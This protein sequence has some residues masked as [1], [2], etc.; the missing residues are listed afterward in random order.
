MEHISKHYAQDKVSL[1]HWTTARL[2]RN[3]DLAV[4]AMGEAW[5]YI[6]ING[7][8]SRPRYERELEKSCALIDE[9]A[10]RLDL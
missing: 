6:Q 8:R 3:L 9:L 7:D 5:F 1:E 4:R 2:L 10:R